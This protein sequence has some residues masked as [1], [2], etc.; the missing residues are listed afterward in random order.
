MPELH[1]DESIWPI[2]FRLVSEE[3]KIGRWTTLS[4]S[5]EDVCLYG[6]EEKESLAA[7]EGGYVLPLELYRHERSDYRFNLSSRDP[8]LFIV[9]EEENEQ[10]SPLLITASQGLASGYMDGDY[11]VLHIQTPI[12]VQAWMEA[13][14]GRHGEQIEFR[15]NRC[16]DKN[17]K[18]RSSGN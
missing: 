3:K 9:C 16:R 5:I 7:V 11:Q 18:G 15:K 17:R 2:G 14:I 4:W 13:Y 12:Q 10:L 8:H 1:K 6:E